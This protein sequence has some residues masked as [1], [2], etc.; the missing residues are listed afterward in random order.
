[1]CTA[2]SFKNNDFYFG[3]TLD[4]EYHFDEKNVITP[5]NYP[6][7]FN[8]THDICSHEAIIGT[9]TVV[10]G[11]PLYYDAMNE[12]GLCVAA[13]SFPDRAKY[14]DYKENC[15]NLASY[16][17]IPWVLCNFR[18]VCDLKES[19][20]AVNLTNK[21]FNDDFPPTSLHWMISD[22][23]SS[24]TVESTSDGLKVYE[25]NIG[26]L[27]NAPEF[28]YHMINLA[29][30]MNLTSNIPEN[31]F[32]SELIIDRYSKGLG[33]FGLP[34]DGSS[35]SR[36][37][38]ASFMKYNSESGSSE[39]EN[40]SR[41]FHIMDSVTQI[42]GSIKLEDGKSFYTVY[43]SCCN[44]DKGIYYYTTYNNRTVT[45]IEM[46]KSNID[47]KDLICVPFIDELEIRYL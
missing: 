42:K 40:I 23:Y 12:S 35:L 3:R 2:L 28:P 8:Y 14:F 27:T 29:N 11:Y 22:K 45:A 30:Y 21:Y 15:L 20:T 25:N 16:E 32:S 7:K 34:G 26:I 36:F 41:F 39:N 4:L 44:A 18:S 33:S 43:T 19:L 37:V 5:H 10:D 6:F 17:F 13:L 24:L 9:A 47:S 1:M 38:R 31:R 46:K